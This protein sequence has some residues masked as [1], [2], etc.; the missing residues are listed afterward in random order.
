M[1]SSIRMRP[2]TIMMAAMISATIAPR[3]GVLCLGPV[4]SGVMA[5]G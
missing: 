2:S 1:T 5:E 4:S 3:H